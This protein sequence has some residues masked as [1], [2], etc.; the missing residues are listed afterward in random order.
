MGAKR[1]TNKTMPRHGPSNL[2]CFVINGSQEF[3]NENEAHKEN[4]PI[5]RKPH[6]AGRAAISKQSKNTSSPN[7][8]AEIQ[9][10]KHTRGPETIQKHICTEVFA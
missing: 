2:I 9:K 4:L 5:Q 6:A 10:S 7:V 3:S 1:K 8:K